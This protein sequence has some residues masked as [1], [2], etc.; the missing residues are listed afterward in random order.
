MGFLNGFTNNETHLL[1]RMSI[2]YVSVSAD[3]GVMGTRKDCSGRK[4]VDSLIR[5]KQEG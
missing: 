5:V 4:K 2:L 3:P 1:I